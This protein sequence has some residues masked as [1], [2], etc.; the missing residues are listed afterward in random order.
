MT[1]A[2]YLEVVSLNYSLHNKN[3][4]VSGGK[5]ILRVSNLKM[6]AIILISI[7]KC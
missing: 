2:L 3:S 7:L 5:I 4:L 6:I 1:Q